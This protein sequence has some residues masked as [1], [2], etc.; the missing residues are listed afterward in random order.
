[1]KYFLGVFVLLLIVACGTASNDGNTSGESQAPSDPSEDV[2]TGYV[3]K[4]EEN[5]I[6][7]T[8][9][10]LDQPFDE[11]AAE[12]VNQQAGNA[13]SFNIEDIENS[14]AESFTIGEKIAVTHGAVAESYPG[15][16]AA[17]T[18]ER[19]I[20]NEHDLVETHGDYA[21]LIQL[22]LFRQKVENEKSS[23]L[24]LVRHTTEGDLIYH[25][26]QYKDGN[27][28]VFVDA[29]QD[30]YG[31]EETVREF[32]CE[33][34]EYYLT[35]EETLSFDL[36][37]CENEGGQL[38]VANVPFSEMIIPEQR[39]HRLEVILNDE[40][41][42]DTTDE[43]K[44]EEIINKIKEAQPQSVMAM[45]L[46]APEGELILKGKMAEIRFD[47]YPEGNVMRYNSYISSN[48]Q[49]K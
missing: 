6:L 17:I 44:K 13:I 29:T 28:Q 24:R 16:S 36:Q 5:R 12:K 10:Q 43:G 47:Y 42:I 11:I 19:V 33:Q 45:S 49:V 20:D 21:N 22:E 48:I 30:E 39:Y 46:M 8:E 9:K 7:V 3:A 40:V 27:Y 23:N 15:Q 34:F 37:N 38:P 1:M 41:L 31:V 14:L 18:I 25:N 35:E 32:A 4:T 26:I 2:M